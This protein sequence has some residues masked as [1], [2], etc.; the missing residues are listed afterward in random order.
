MSFA[1][2]LL[3]QLSLTPAP[4]RGAAW[5]LLAS[6]AF[7]S[8]TVLVRI[9]GKDMHPFEI[10][11]WRNFYGLV[12]MLPWIASVGFSGLRTKRIGAYTLRGIFGLTAMLLWFWSITLMPLGEAVALS[13]T[14]PLFASVAAVVV[15]RE[16]MGLRRSMALAAGFAG[17]LIIL[18]PGIIPVSTPALLV[19]LSSVFIA[20]S[21]TMVKILSRTESPAAIVTWMGLFLTPLS[22]I[23]AVFFWRWPTLTETMMLIVMGGFA[24]IG[25][26]AM[27]R[28]YAVTE[29]TI[30]LPFD[31][32]R[33][34]FAA[35]I[36]FIIFA[37]IPDGWTWIGA[38]V[39][40]VAT[41][42]MAHREAQIARARKGVRI[43][44]VTLGTGGAELAA[45]PPARKDTP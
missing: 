9:L 2:T 38:A 19:L 4:L 31:Y 39:M 29:A 23:P 8:M 7:A 20:C 1:R 45:P 17:A 12:F 6:A 5:M 36:A 25:Q 21:V 41:V 40:A 26:M 44:T 32:A 42:Y 3:H 43:G 28:A 27:T 16:H 34:P 22:L 15:L 24:T 30:V 33:L 14:A 35:A 37:E 13:F 18:R 10:T 11:F